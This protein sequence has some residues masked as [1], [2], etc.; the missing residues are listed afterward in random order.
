VRILSVVTLVSPDGAYGGPLRVAVNQA[1]GLRDRGHDVTIVAAYSGYPAGPPTHLGGVPAHLF[2]ARR[3]VPGTGFA[4]LSAPGLIAHVLRHGRDYDIAHVHVARDLVTLPAA[5]ILRRLRVPYVLQCH[6]M[7]N[8]S[9]HPLAR[10]LD[11]V[12]TRP[13][14][15]AAAKL[16]YLTST[17]RG[18]LS[19]IVGSENSLELLT[20]GVPPTELLADTSTPEVLFL[21]RLAER[22]RPAVMIE[23]AD[24]LAV[25]HPDYRIRLV[26]PDEGEGDAVRA[27]I[28]ASAADIAWEGALN[29][30]ETLSRMAQAGLYVLPSVD[31]P[32]CMSVL[33]AMSVGLPV[34]ITPSN[35]LA[36]LVRESGAGLVS[37]PATSELITAVRS[38]IEDRAAAT[39]M[40]QAGRQVATRQLG[41]DAI[42]DKLEQIYGACA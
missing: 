15:R 25:D 20:N 18:D 12:L 41:M 10:V 34:V 36:S 26:G 22:K 29:P 11:P 13:V 39:A 2:P 30:T 42:T 35:G 8:A 17:E 38:I 5:F 9:Q 16:L 4:G 21:A 23:I 6:G 7:I 40:G 31:E 33:E 14:L 32:Y 3:L 24:A 28:A 19:R 27:G 37:G 1:E